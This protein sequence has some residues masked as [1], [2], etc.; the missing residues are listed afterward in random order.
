MQEASVSPPPNGFVSRD[1]QFTEL[2][3]L[4]RR[5]RLVTLTG[6]PGAGKSRLLVEYL[7]RNGLETG[8]FVDLTEADPGADVT[9]ALVAAAAGARGQETLLVLDGCDHVIGSCARTISALLR[10]DGGLRVLATSREAFRIAG[11]SVCPVPP[12][13]LGQAVALF[14]LRMAERN[15]SVTGVDQAVLEELCRRLD[16]LPLA[17]E[18]AA[19]SCD[20]MSPGDLLRRLDGRIEVLAGG[21][22]SGPVRQQSLAA[23][24]DWSFSL[25][26]DAE[27]TLLG[28]LAVFDGTFSLDD[29]EQVCAG[30]GAGAPAIFAGIAA[31]AGKSLVGCETAGA[32]V[33]YG[34]LTTVRAAVRS[35][36][37]AQAELA[38]SRP[39]HVRWC[40]A[41]AEA[42][43]QGGSAAPGDVPG[44]AA[45]DAAGQ[46]HGDAAELSRRLD[47]IAAQYGDMT[48][49]LTWCRS[50]APGAGLRLAVALGLYWQVRGPTEDG[51]RWFGEL[52]EG[53]QGNSP[54]AGLGSCLDEGS[55]AGLDAGLGAGRARLEYG[56]LLCA[57]GEFSRARAE[58]EEALRCFEAA[59]DEPGRLDALMLLGSVRAVTDGPGGGKLLEEIAAS[60]AGGGGWRTG[61]AVALL[62]AAQAFTGDLAAA[63]RACLAG[64]RAAVGPLGR[65][66]G[67]IALGHI[68]LDQG[69]WPEGQR[70][71]DLARELAQQLGFPRGVAMA[72][73]GL[74][75]AAAAA[76]RAAEARERLAEAVAAARAAEVPAVLASCLNEQARLLLG[77]DPAAARSLSRRV[78]AA[79][80][81]IPAREVAAALLGACHA[82][83]ADGA[84][85]PARSLAEEAAVLARRVGDKLTAARALHAHGLAARMGGDTA[86]AWALQREALA[87]RAE[88]GAA[89]G[90]AESLEAL[91]GVC[92]GQGRGR[93]A[94][95]L[96]GAAGKLR[97][98]L[99]MVPGPDPRRAR[100][101]ALAESAGAAEFGRGWARGQRTEEIVT[102][103]LSR[104]GR[105]A[106]ATGWGALTRAEIEVARLAAEGLTNREIG[107]RLFVSPRTVQTHLSHVFG[108]LEVASRRELTREMR[109]RTRSLGQAEV[110]LRRILGLPHETPAGPGSAVLGGSWRPAISWSNP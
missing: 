55:G 58:A 38:V 84:A 65:L 10:A 86:A 71:L 44:D 104:E 106:A 23:A 79:A 83:L 100:D 87:I 20:V 7:I 88:L 3:A 16:R 13:G 35:A 56:A 95:E 25:L 36:S 60:A 96:F 91:A 82:E 18:L 107:A 75:T 5:G 54:G 48:G 45:G 80:G 90:I 98:D 21:D 110:P 89:P 102:E 67:E 59:P 1:A 109:T 29:A 31:L 85:D 12:L 14:T 39:E 101:V 93:E 9:A 27:R 66:A 78:L 69:D 103:T 41:L 81:A 30:H 34:L 37:W 63:R 19:A 94:G 76:G 17:I 51:C 53:G 97:A 43:G 99:G 6:P 8:G 77:A 24:L 33:R 68:L 73:K 47:Q 74:G 40:V 28:R 32:T 92:A 42:S 4:L 105:R 2:D 50:A 64:A 22:R 49:A 11:E 70:S 72:A 26:E 57:R 62:G 46:R 61:I 15:S 108:K 52:L